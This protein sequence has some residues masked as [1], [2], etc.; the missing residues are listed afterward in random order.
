MPNKKI[1]IIIGSA[2]NLH[3]LYRDQFKFLRANGYEIT[4]LA[5]A[6]VEHEWL[7]EQGFKT[8]IIHL[9]REPSVFHDLYSLLKLTWFFIFNRFDIINISTP[10]A[11]LIGSLAAYFS[12][13]RNIVYNLRGRAYESTTGFTRFFYEK[14]E[15]LV[16]TL[17][18]IVLSDSKEIRK[19]VIE[20]NICRAE[21]IVVFG[22]GSSNGVD[23][24]KFRKTAKTNE[25]R[26]SI[27]KDLGLNDHDIL[28]LN[29]GRLRNDKGIN[30]LVRAFNSLSQKYSHIHL[31]LQGKYENFDPLE[32]DVLACI[33]SHPRIHQAG[34]VKDVQ[35][36]FAAA[37][38]F[39]FPSHREGFGNVA[40][41][42]SAMELP[43]VAFDVVGCRE[44]IK[45]NVSGLLCEYINYK[46]FERGLEKL[47]DDSELR[48]SM[49]QKG[50]TRVEKEFDSQKI[51]QQLLNVYDTIIKEKLNQTEDPALE[52]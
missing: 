31:L 48:N 26:V 25:E 42:A 38:I 12:F 17:S 19:D 15:K 28:I 51:W 46:S 11:S 4:G 39:A 13:H 6:G 33:K 24:K 1:C 32:E 47:I 22:S 10:K 21:K 23:L 29:S 30:E 43:V 9:K 35:N 40:I 45:A 36:Y 2:M 20:K 50:R 34:W 16:C 37:D 5:P 18:L 7:R 27:R 14:I 52:N 49:G 44:S 41:E 3:G 8:E